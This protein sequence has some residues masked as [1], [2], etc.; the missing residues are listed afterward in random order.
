MLAQRAPGDW[1][2]KEREPGSFTLWKHEWFK[3]VE[4]F[5][6]GKTF[7]IT[8]TSQCMGEHAKNYLLNTENMEK[9]H[10][11]WPVLASSMRRRAVSQKVDKDIHL[12]RSGRS[13]ATRRAVSQKLGRGTHLEMRG[14]LEWWGAQLES[15]PRYL[16]GEDRGRGSSLRRSSVS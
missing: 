12:E 4:T 11:Q 6:R 5:K 14:G 2:Y 3:E 16:L 8:N 15:S 10:T 7:I 1:C 9:I 13:W